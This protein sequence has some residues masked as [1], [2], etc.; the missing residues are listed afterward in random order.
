MPVSISEVV[1]AQKMTE[2][3]EFA[4]QLFDGGLGCLNV[5]YA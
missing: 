2:T 3:D 4:L 5:V 1:W